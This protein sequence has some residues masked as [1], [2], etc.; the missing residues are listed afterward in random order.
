MTFPFYSLPVLR[1]Y[2]TFTN[3]I[4]SIAPIRR[5]AAIIKFAADMAIASHKRVSTAFP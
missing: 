5:A 4:A 2:Q 1:R 3:Q